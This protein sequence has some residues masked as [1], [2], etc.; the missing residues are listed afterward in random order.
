MRAFRFISSSVN[1][2]A[3]GLALLPQGA[4]AVT[5]YIA[6]QATNGVIVVSAAPCCGQQT[7]VTGDG[8]TTASLWLALWWHPKIEVL[9]AKTNVVRITDT[10][11]NGQIMATCLNRAR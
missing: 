4:S 10:H 7:V 8:V 2:P 1:L 9:S 5:N 11:A 3:F 6:A